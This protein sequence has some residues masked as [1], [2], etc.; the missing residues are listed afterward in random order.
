MLGRRSEIAR[1]QS[2]FYRDKFRKTLRWLL[3][4]VL[5]MYLLVAAIVYV[6]LFQP[7][8]YYYANTTD[9][10]VISMPMPIVQTG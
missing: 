3:F 8:Q 9:G 6:I 2:D 5:A 10:E 4:S 7:Q 1:L